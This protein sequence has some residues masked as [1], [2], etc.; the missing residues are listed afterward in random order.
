METVRERQRGRETVRE[1]GRET[2]V[3]GPSR[4]IGGAATELTDITGLW[5]D[6]GCVYVFCASISSSIKESERMCVFSKGSMH[7]QVCLCET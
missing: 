5:D 4:L 2:P 1:G 7:A 3:G 6:G